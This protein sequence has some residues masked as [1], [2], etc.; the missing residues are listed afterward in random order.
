MDITCGRAAAAERQQLDGVVE[1]G[2]IAAARSDDRQQLFDV[3]P[4]QRGSQNGLPRVHPVCIPAQRVDFTVVADVAV[5]MRQLPARKRV[6]R[7]ALVDQAQRAHHFGIGQFL[8]EIRDL[9]SQKQSLVN[10]RPR[11]K[12]RDVEEILFLEVGFRHG[13]FRRFAQDVELALERVLIH[14]RRA[15]DE[16]LLDVGLRVARHAPDRVSVDR[17]VAPAEHGQ[18]LLARG[19]LH[20]AFAEDSV[21][22]IDGKKY[23]PDAIFAGRGKRETEARA[24]ALEKSVRNLNQDA[25]AVARLRIAAARAAMREIDQNLNTLQHDIVGFL[26]FDIGDET[27]AASVVLVLR[28]VHALRF[29][30]ARKWVDG[31]HFAPLFHDAAEPRRGYILAFLSSSVLLQLVAPAQ[32]TFV[33]PTHQKYKYGRICIGKTGATPAMTAGAAPSAGPAIPGGGAAAGRR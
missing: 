26:P 19:F 3:F 23:H 33:Y 4:E 16:N 18:P 29:G 12:R 10:N 21:L 14:A 11:R 15:P 28:A 27:E 6:G 1:H 31:F 24:F 5:G 7:E 2:R 17:R 25:R 20:D 32:D 9:R 22:R 30:Q 13:G 8:V